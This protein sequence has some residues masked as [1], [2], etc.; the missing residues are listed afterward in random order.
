[1]F[2]SIVSIITTSLLL[3]LFVWYKKQRC[4]SK[5]SA[6][7][8]CTSRITGNT[9]GDI[10]RS[11]GKGTRLEMLRQWSDESDEDFVRRASIGTSFDIRIQPS[12]V[13]SEDPSEVS[14]SEL[15]YEL[16]EH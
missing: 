14:V 5:S 8:Q 7:T 15:S 13:S 2:V 12:A 3:A 9:P 6:G 4:I 11:L 1:M 16:V 10:L